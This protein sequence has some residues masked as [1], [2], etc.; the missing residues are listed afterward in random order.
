MAV[1]AGA[2]DVEAVAERQ[3]LPEG[4]AA[5]G[6]HVVGEF[7][8]AQRALDRG[9]EV[10]EGLLVVPHVRAGA[11]ARAVIGVLAFPGPEL[12]VFEPDDGGCAEQGESGARGVLHFG[13]QGRAEEAVAEGEGFGLELVPALQRV[14]GARQRV[15][16]L[17]RVIVGP[18]RRRLVGDD[19]VGLLA[20]GPVDIA[21]GE[22]PGDDEAHGFAATGRHGHPGA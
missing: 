17:G 13:R 21:L 15:R 8:L 18:A 10:G 6:Q 3:L 19:A 2:D 11:F 12:A 9:E 22:A 20:E 5:G 16:P 14:G 4:Q 7:G 1:G